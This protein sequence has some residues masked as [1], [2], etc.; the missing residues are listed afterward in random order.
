MADLGVS[1]YRSYF[2]YKAFGAAGVLASLPKSQELSPVPPSPA[3]NSIAKKTSSSASFTSDV[4]KHLD[5][6]RKGKAYLSEET[7]K[8]LARQSQGASDI[9]GSLSPEA[10]SMYSGYLTGL[11]YERK[12]RFVQQAYE[13]SENIASIS[14]SA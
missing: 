3:K 11:S 5:D 6:Y 4:E 9:L 7:S 8:E 12:S 14:Q 13:A 2:S 10:R 1:L